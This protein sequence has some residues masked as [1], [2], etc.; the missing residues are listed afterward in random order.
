[1]VVPRTPRPPIIVPKP[2]ERSVDLVEIERW[3]ARLA[4]SI[5]LKRLERGFLRGGGRSGDGDAGAAG[6]VDG[7]SERH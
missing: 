4:R 5:R 3:V 6:T 7:G 2:A 1:M